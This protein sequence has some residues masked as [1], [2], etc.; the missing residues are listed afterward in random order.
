MNSSRE[1]GFVFLRF[2]A[3]PGEERVN[4][5]GGEGITERIEHGCELYVRHGS[6]VVGIILLKILAPDARFF[7]C[8]I[9]RP[10][11]QDNL[12][13]SDDRIIL[14]LSR[15]LF[16]RWQ[17]QLQL[18]HRLLLIRIIIIQ[19]RNRIPLRCVGQQLRHHKAR[20]GNM[21]VGRRFI[22]IKD[23]KLHLES[24]FVFADVK[25]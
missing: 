22:S 24:A 23:C 19:P 4:R 2:L 15:H 5:F 3:V 18:L 9:K 8:K 11:E 12:P 25:K 13:E 10:N 20:I 16:N 17:R 6:R 1:S 7:I 14:C 21:I